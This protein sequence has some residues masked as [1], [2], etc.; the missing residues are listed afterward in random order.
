MALE[1]NGQR[2]GAMQYNGVTISEAMIDG[3][4][5]YRSSPYPMTGSW[6]PYSGYG[7]TRDT[8]YMLEAGTFRITHTMTV[9]SGTGGGTREARINVIGQS[10]VTGPNAG[11]STAT[12]TWTVAK[13]A[14]V[15]FGTVTGQGTINAT[16]IWTIERI[17]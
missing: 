3:Q 4:I 2:V 17:G 9:I 10:A 5:V 8:H 13:N 14:R 16:G 6:G 1:Y 12:G 15:E 7:G 11:T